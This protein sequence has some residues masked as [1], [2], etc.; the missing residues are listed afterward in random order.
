MDVSD[1]PEDTFDSSDIIKKYKSI[2]HNFIN[3]R[4]L[5]FFKVRLIKMV[6]D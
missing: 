4:K 3:K 5:G 2:R 1:L 6:L